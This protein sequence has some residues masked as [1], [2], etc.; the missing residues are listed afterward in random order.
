MI[1]T[2]KYDI[3]LIL[4]VIVSLAIILIKII[5]SGNVGN[6]FT[7]FIIVGACVEYFDFI[8]TKQKDNE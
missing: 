4:I 7:T 6:I 5:D 3:R 1:P 2:S 8:N